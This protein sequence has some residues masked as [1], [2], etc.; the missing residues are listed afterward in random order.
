MALYKIKDFYPN[1][2]EELFDGDDIKGYDVYAGNTDEKIGSVEDALVDESGYFRY[3]VIDTGFWIFGKKVLIPI[4]RCRVDANDRRVYAVGLEN[5][6]QAEQLPEYH[7]DMTIDSAYEQRV[8]SVYTTPSVENS[9]A[10][11]ATPP[12]EASGVTA[13]TGETAVDRTEG[14]DTYSYER[15]PSLYQVTEQDHRQLKLYEERLL[16]NK[17]RHKT[18]EVTVGKRVETETARAAVPVEKEKVIVEVT[19]AHGEEARVTP[20]EHDF[21]DGEVARVE[22]YEENAEIRKQAFVRGEVEVRKEVERDTVEATETIRREE[23]EVKR[24]GN[25]VVEERDRR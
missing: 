1:Y 14:Y 15:E 6:D 22:V 18:G 13:R 23:L 24:E 5:K 17:H 11:E 20:G 16:A 12:V 2:R 9:A 10:V 19:D 21:H 8:R 7:A 3:L 25:P 4:G